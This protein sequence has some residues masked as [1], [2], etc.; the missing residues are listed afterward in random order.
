MTYEVGFV[1][2]PGLE[3]FQ[4]ADTFIVFVLRYC[5]GLPHDIIPGVLEN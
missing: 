2:Y 4:M 3:A 5:V 1:S